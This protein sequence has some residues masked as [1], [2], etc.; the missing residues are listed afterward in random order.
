MLVLF[1]GILIFY[2]YMYNVLHFILNKSNQS[3][4][5][6]LKP[7]VFNEGYKILD[8]EENWHRRKEAKP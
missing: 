4:Q 7:P 6:E 5:V 8:L 2:V 3:I 1:C